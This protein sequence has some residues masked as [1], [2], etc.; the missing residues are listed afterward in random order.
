[1]K[2]KA[3]PL[4]FLALGLTVTLG[5]SPCV[6]AQRSPAPENIY[7]LV[8][9]IEMQR[10]NWLGYKASVKL[11]FTTNHGQT[12]TCQGTLTYLRLEEKILLQCYNSNKN[13]LFVFK[14][15]DLDF[16]LF[17][18]MQKTLYQ[19]NI[20]DL[21]FSDDVDSHIKPYD[22]YRAL[23]PMIIPFGSVRLESRDKLL[24]TFVVAE[25]R[26]GE[27]YWGRRVTANEKGD[28]LL[29]DYF[30]ADGN[31][32]LAV[33]REDYKKVSGKGYITKDPVRFPRRIVMRSEKDGT[34]TEILFIKMDL[35]EK[36]ISANWK[37]LVPP[38][39]Q[40][41]AFP[42]FQPEAASF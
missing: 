31:P 6:W 2:R 15:S 24:T 28:V 16:E 33:K 11:N 26:K 7:A 5:G 12:A 21:E 39:T 23:K 17:M 40:T 41:L 36:P 4:F 14:T 27:T 20:F 13:T 29:E 37:I 30:D 3:R 22:L 19:G 42:K 32:T 35:I 25:T 18:P 34:Q 1:M 8:N 9:R 38:G 10:Y